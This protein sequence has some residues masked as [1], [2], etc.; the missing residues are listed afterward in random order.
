MQRATD[1]TLREEVHSITRPSDA[2]PE[3]TWLAEN[4]ARPNDPEDPPRARR[5]PRA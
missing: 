4:R 2:L 5:R 1:N 3:V